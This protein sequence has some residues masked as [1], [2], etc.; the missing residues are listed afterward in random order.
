MPTATQPPHYQYPR[1]IRTVA[2]IGAGAAGCPAARQ[3]REH[4]LKVRV[5]ERQDRPGGVWNWSPDIA[6]P[7]SVPTPPPSRGAFKPVLPEVQPG[8][9]PTFRPH[10]GDKRT[11]HEFSPPNP[12]YKSLSNNVPT[13]TMVVSTLGYASWCQD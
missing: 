10:A 4:G 6:P 5:F 13:S 3:L 12:V 7:L 1:P 9:T 2:V 11:L 8:P